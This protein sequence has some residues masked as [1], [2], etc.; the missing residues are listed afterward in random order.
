MSKPDE[1]GVPA[2]AHFKAAARRGSVHAKRMLAGPRLPRQL[3]YLWTW[4]M[5]LRAGLPIDGLNGLPRL[6]WTALQAWSQLTGTTPRPHEV[7][8]LFV[9][10]DAVRNPPAQVAL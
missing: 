1:S 6:T 10:D 3:A 2:R 4:L 5:E 9:L 7:R 8:A